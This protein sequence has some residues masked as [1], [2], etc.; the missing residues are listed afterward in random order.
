MTRRTRVLWQVGQCGACLLGLVLVVAG[1][2]IIG[3]GELGYLP[4]R[5]QLWGEL[6]ALALSL[7]GLALCVL[8]GLMRYRP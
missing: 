2:A 8:A 1:I 6:L 7:V 4:G 3:F 5:S